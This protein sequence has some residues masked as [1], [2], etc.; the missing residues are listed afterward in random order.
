MIRLYAAEMRNTVSAVIP[1]WNSDRSV[2]L[3]GSPNSTRFARVTRD[4]GLT[5]SCVPVTE[6]CGRAPTA[7]GTPDPCCEDI[8]SDSDLDLRSN[9]RQIR[10]VVLPD[11]YG[12]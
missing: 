5:P 3:R 12:V 2:R 1:A 11:A 4:G 8:D 9:P 7:P 10:P 6:P